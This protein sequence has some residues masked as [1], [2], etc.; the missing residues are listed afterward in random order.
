LLIIY[1]SIRVFGGIKARLPSKYLH[2]RI[3]NWAMTKSII[4]TT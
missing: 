4:S 3:D 2:L 1:G